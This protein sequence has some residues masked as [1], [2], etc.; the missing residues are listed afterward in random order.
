LGVSRQTGDSSLFFSALIHAVKALSVGLIVASKV[1][2]G[3]SFL[4]CF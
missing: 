1:P 2:L 3:L 4:F